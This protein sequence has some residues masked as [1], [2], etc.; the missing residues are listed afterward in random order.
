M[1]HGFKTFCKV[2]FSALTVILFSFSAQADEVE[3]FNGRPV[4]GRVIVD[5][6]N[7]ASTL[8]ELESQSQLIIRGIIQDG[9]ENLVQDNNFGYTKTTVLITDVLK[10]DETM[11]DSTI[12][13]REPYILVVRDGITGYIINENYLPS[14]TGSEYILFLGKSSDDI[15]LYKGTYYLLYDEKGKYPIRDDMDPEHMTTSFYVDNLTNAQLN[16]GPKDSSEYRNIYKSI[17]NK[18]ILK[19]I[20]TITKTTNEMEVINKNG[21]LYVPLR[22]TA[23][24]TGCSVEWNSETSTACVKKENHTAEFTTGK[25]IYILNRHICEAET[26]PIISEGKMYIPLSTVKQG[27]GVD[28]VYDYY[29]STITF[30]CY[31]YSKNCAD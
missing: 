14:T 5:Y 26:P 18:Y 12:V 22:Y 20:T 30:N 10:G 27:L 15:E 1:L 3:T 13:F 21:I 7:V 4:F 28:V 2:F 8:A 23:E 25:D 11:T 31:W 16:I 29:N 24:L 9:Q 6:D 17:I 19:N